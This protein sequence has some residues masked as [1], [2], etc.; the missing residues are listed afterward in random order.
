MSIVFNERSMSHEFKSEILTLA[1]IC[2]EII[3]IYASLLYQNWMEQGQEKNCN[4][5]HFLKTT[6]QEE[7]TRL[8]VDCAIGLLV[9]R[10]RD[11]EQPQPLATSAAET[12]EIL[13]E[14]QAGE[15][16][17]GEKT[18]EKAEE[19]GEKE[20]GGENAE[21]RGEK[22]EERGENAEGRGEKT[23]EGGE[24]TEEGGEKTEEGVEK[25]GE[26]GEEMEGEEMEGEGGEEMEGEKTEEEG[27]KTE[28]EGEKTEEEGEKTEEE[29]EKTEEGGENEEMR[30]ISA[31]MND[32]AMQTL[33]DKILDETRRPGEACSCKKHCHTKIPQNLREEYCKKYWGMKR[34]CRKEGYKEFGRV[35][36]YKTQGFKRSRQ[37]TFTLYNDK[38]Q[39]VNLCQHFFMS[40][41]GY[42]PRSKFPYFVLA[43]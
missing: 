31:T 32:D 26:E 1:D 2:K 38:K 12:W 33:G 11:R 21:E 42:H 43:K 13:E 40:T 35:I 34:I 9:H 23:E 19:R 4:D 29:G 10:I 14:I 36:K 27:E 17:G 28:E 30:E 8:T 6:L 39:A 41:L 25:E 15:K 20:E 5:E 24:K 16:E 7:A 22:E 3:E 18:E 37:K